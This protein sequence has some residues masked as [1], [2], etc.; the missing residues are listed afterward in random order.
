VISDRFLW[1]G[2]HGDVQHYAGASQP[3]VSVGVRLAGLE[4]PAHKDRRHNY[5]TC[6]DAVFISVYFPPSL[7]NS[8]RNRVL[9]RG[10]HDSGVLNEASRLVRQVEQTS[11]PSAGGVCSPANFGIRVP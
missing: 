8:E 10:A 2:L 3:R 1:V 7:L 4:S 5:A 6:S 9:I 11:G